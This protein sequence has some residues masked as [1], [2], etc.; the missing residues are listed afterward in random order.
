MKQKAKYIRLMESMLNGKTFSEKS[1]ESTYKV[2]SARSMLSNI[3][4][5]GVTV[6]CYKDKKDNTRYRIV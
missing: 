3:R 4:A 1:I 6:E 5:L 2:K